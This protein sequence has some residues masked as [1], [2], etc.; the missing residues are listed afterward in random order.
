MKMQALIVGLGA[1]I[2]PI[3]FGVNLITGVYIKFYNDSDKLVMFA[4]ISDYLN[5]G[6]KKGTLIYGQVF[7]DR[8]KVS[9]DLHPWVDDLDSL[10]GQ[11]VDFSVGGSLL[12][13][14]SVSVKM[15]S[16]DSDGNTK[17][18]IS[19]EDIGATG[20][21]VADTMIRGTFKRLP[22]AKGNEVNPVAQ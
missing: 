9:S 16:I 6:G 18:L 17:S 19:K 4:G 2:K 15:S 8:F 10:V 5:I 22:I 21:Q 1:S 13:S 20:V 7:T 11:K 12:V 14:G 3:N